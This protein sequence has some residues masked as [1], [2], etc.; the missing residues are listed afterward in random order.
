MPE[1]LGT[2]RLSPLQL[3]GRRTEELASVWRSD[4]YTMSAYYHIGERERNPVYALQNGRRAHRCGIGPGCPGAQMPMR[5]GVGA[6][7]PS[8]LVM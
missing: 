1:S 8:H 6:N 7:L 4:L 2:Y 3:K 5:S